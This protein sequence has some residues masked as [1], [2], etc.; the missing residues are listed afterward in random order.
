M[1]G[2]K[3]KISVVWVGEYP[4]DTAMTKVM[5]GARLN[6]ANINVTGMKAKPR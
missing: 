3:K 4:Q 1:Q 2:S 6:M 5:A